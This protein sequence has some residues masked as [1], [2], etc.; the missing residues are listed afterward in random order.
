MLET[1]C[2]YFL[3][4]KLIWSNARQK[5]QSIY[6]GDVRKLLIDFCVFIYIISVTRF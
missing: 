6:M 2:Y 3:D 5:C 4:E 1:R